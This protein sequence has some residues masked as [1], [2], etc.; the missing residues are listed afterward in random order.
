[1]GWGGGGCSYCTVPNT[2]LLYRADIGSM[3]GR[4]SGSDERPRASPAPTLGLGN[5]ILI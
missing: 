4:E 3:Q 5:Q 1:M 2:Q